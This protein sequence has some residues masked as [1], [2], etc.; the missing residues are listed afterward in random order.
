MAE[1]KLH[2]RMERHDDEDGVYYVVEGVEIGLVTDGEIIEEALRH[3][4]EAVELYYED[5]HLPPATSDG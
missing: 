4:R 1:N 3:L 2:F 5:D